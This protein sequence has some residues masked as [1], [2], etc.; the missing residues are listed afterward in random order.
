MTE[1][2]Y[3]ILLTNSLKLFSQGPLLKIKNTDLDVSQ[4]SGIL[5]RSMTYNCTLISSNTKL[6][7]PIYAAKLTNEVRV[8]KNVINITL[9]NKFSD[10]DKILIKL[11]D[12]YSSSVTLIES[13]VLSR[14]NFI[15]FWNILFKDIIDEYKLEAYYD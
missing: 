13:K 4:F 2:L 5:V 9:N 12:D 1:D 15:K 7:N 11:F 3:S 10:K 8:R 14:D 6:T